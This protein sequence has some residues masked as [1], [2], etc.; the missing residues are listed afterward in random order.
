MEVLPLKVRSLLYEHCR[1]TGDKPLD[2][3]IDVMTL[4]LD[5]VVDHQ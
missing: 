3:I 2:V 1:Q 4:Y 5:E